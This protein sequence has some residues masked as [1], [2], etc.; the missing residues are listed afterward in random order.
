M[1]NIDFVDSGSM[2]EAELKRYITYLEDVI[3]NQNEYIEFLEDERS[4]L[5]EMISNS[6][7][8]NEKTSALQELR[9]KIK[10]LE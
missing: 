7:K 5:I 2:E 3:S 9:E 1:I 4:S 8:F 6:N 10:T